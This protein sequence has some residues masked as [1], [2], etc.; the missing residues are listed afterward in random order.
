MKE[1]KRAEDPPKEATREMSSLTLQ[2]SSKKRGKTLDVVS[3]LQKSN[4]K[5][6]A[7]FVVIGKS[8]PQLDHSSYQG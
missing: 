6:T 7:S 1:K 4:M 3:E 5:D 2:D 8:C